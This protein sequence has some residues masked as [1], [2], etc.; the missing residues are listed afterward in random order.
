MGRF[1]E[2]LEHFPCSCKRFQNLM[3]KAPEGRKGLAHG[4]SRGYAGSA[5]PTA[6]ERQK[7]FDC[8]IRR[9]ALVLGSPIKGG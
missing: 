8:I 3:A 1:R 2:K 5:A 7:I 4:V 9:N 6:P